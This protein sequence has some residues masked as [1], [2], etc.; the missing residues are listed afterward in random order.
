MTQYEIDNR[1]EFYPRYGGSGDEST[2]RIIV[3]FCFLQT[4]HL[5]LT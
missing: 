4:A 1:G 2:Q 5:P 3:N